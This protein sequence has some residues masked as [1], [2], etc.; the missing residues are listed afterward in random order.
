MA[1][2]KRPV[3]SRAAEN[4]FW[5]GRYTERAENSIRLAQIILRNLHGEEQTTRALQ[6]WM[7]RLAVQHSLVAMHVPLP[8]L[9]ALSAQP[10][11]HGHAT[12]NTHASSQA[13]NSHTQVLRVFERSLIAALGDAQSSYSVGFNLKALRLAAANVRE[14]LSQ[15]QRNLIERAETEFLDQ[16][17]DVDADTETAPQEALNALEA[18]SEWLAG[19]TG[20]QTDRMVRDN[21]WRLLSIG[22]HIERLTTLAQAMRQAFESCSVHEHAGFEALVA[23]FDSTITF[24]AQYQQRRDMPALLDLLVID[25]LRLKPHP[26]HLSVDEALALA[27]GLSPR[28]LLLTHICHDLSHDG[29]ERHCAAAGLP[30]PAG[31]AWDGL[32]VDLP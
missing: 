8:P 10:A 31:P 19:I 11:S 23:L 24:H 12:A 20:A 13:P 17:S 6:G 14:R 30:F 29:L 18:A 1:Q 3:T 16:C 21:G 7:S 22:R 27:R 15:E 5:L 26:T 25:A 4:L 32:S 9:P 2:A 28:R